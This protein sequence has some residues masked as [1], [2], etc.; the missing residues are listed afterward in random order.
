MNQSSKQRAASI[1]IPMCQCSSPLSRDNTICGCDV[2]VRSELDGQ[3]AL[4][5]LP[6]DS[7]KKMVVA[8]VPERIKQHCGSLEDPLH[9]ERCC[10]CHGSPVFPL[11]LGSLSSQSKTTDWGGGHQADL[12]QTVRYDGT[13]HYK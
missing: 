3:T 10:P 8:S 2:D 12:P 7:L 9:C 1:E 13:D 11:K 6:N 4:I 5:I